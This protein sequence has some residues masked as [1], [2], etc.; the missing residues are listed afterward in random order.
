VPEHPPPHVSAALDELLDDERR[1]DM[2]R[3]ATGDVESFV[4]YQKGMD[5]YLRAH[6]ERDGAQF[7][8]LLRQSQA[9][10]DQ[11]LA[12]VP[13]LFP[14]QLLRGDVYNHQLLD[15]LLYLGP[16]LPP[17]EARAALAALREGNARTQAAARNDDERASA[18]VTRIYLSDD[19]TGLAAAA[20]RLFAAQGC[21]ET[22]FNDAA[23]AYGLADAAT[24]FYRKQ[25]ACD[26]LELEYYWSQAS[27]LLWL[28]DYAGVASL[29]AQ[30]ASRAE[31]DFRLEWIQMLALIGSGKGDQAAA[32]SGTVA[33]RA[34]FSPEAYAV[35]IAAARGDAELARKRWAAL[36]QAH[37][38][39]RLDLT[40]SAWLGE[41]DAASDI[42]ARMD[43]EALGSVGLAEVVRHCYC[44]APFDID[45]TPNFKARIAE[46]GFAWPPKKPVPTPLKD[47]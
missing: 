24:R 28:G 31:H 26:P 5:L 30:D 46:S 10:F 47:W 20:T 21:V 45:R 40:A 36:P 22:V 11:A 9:A 8:P 14:A 38:N 35:L 33:P 25:I 18:S 19:W 43:G 42:A 13:N 7:Q 12:R 16:A 34:R 39:P 17:A 29:V 15:P 1:A 27:A 3:V 4:A 44:G 23:L 41:R 32:L 2:H 6:L 37:H